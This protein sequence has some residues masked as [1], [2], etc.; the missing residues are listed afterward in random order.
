MLDLANGATYES[1]P[2]VFHNSGATLH[3][4]GNHPN[5]IN[6]NDGFGSECPE[7]L[8]SSVLRKKA[9]IGIAHDGDGDRLV[10]SDEMG[11]I[12]DGDIILGLL[13]RYA[14]RAGTSF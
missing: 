2:A 8:A 12:V 9:N 13:G 1:T 4:I 14:I 6:I 3:M 7:Q 11:V 10:V 5:G